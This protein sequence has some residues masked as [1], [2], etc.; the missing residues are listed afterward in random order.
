MGRSSLARGARALALAGFFLFCAGCGGGGRVLAPIPP[1]IAGVPWPPPQTAL[2]Q[3]SDDTVRLDG[4]DYASTGGDSTLAGRVLHL[5]GGA[6]LSWAIYTVGGFGASIHPAQLD[7]DFSIVPHAPGDGTT[8]WI[9]L[10]DYSRGRWEWHAGTPLTFSQV[11]ADQAHYYSGSSGIAALAVVVTGP[12]MASITE[13]RFHRAGATDIPVP[14]NLSAMAELGVVHLDWDDLPV[15]DGF[16]VYR[17][18]DVDFTDPVKVNAELVLESRYDDTTVGSDITY[19]YRVTAM[20]LNESTPSNVVQVHAPKEDLLVPQNLTATADVGLIS[21]E[22]DDVAGVSGYN[23]YRD[24]KPAFD[25]P[26]K[27][28]ASLV[29]TSDYDDDSVSSG[30][31][32]YYCVTSAHIGESAYSN[33]VDVFAPGADLPA[34]LNPHASQIGLDYFRVAWEWPWARPGSFV[35]Y[36]HKIPNFPL[37]DDRE[38]F[39][40]PTG[41]G[42]SLKIT[43][44][45]DS[46]TYYFRVAARSSGGS[47]GRMTDAIAVT[48]KGYWT[49]GPL[50]E[51]GDGSSAPIVAVVQNGDLTVAYMNGSDVNVARRNAGTWTVDTAVLGSGDVSGGFASYLDMAAWQNQYVVASYAVMPGDLWV[52]TGSA[53]GTWT[54]A[55]VDGDGSTGL[56]HT[57]SGAYCKVAA[58]L[59]TFAVAYQ[60]APSTSLVLRTK[61]GSGAWSSTTTLQTSVVEP[62]FHSLLY[63]GSDL[64]VLRLDRTAQQLLLGDADSGWTWTD[65]AG[66]TGETLG[67]Y[68]QLLKVGT[69]FWTPAENETTGDFYALSGDG[70]TFPWSSTAV[71][72]A[73]TLT[74]P[75]GRQRAVRA[76]QQRL[77]CRVLRLQP[78]PVV[79]RRVQRRGLGLPAAQDAGRHAR[80]VHGSRRDERRAVPRLL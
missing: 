52:A 63:D 69:Q 38:T 42:R 80:N 10:G 7:V 44:R 22:W 48:T 1:R 46:T 30:K 36:V 74:R 5:T 3:A 37:D 78:Q 68:N 50:E 8:L 56:G 61:S 53:G 45:T 59:N 66:T 79:L 23:V 6:A 21:L 71:D 73:G 39:S 11:L 47:A 17:A 31:I 20:K 67:A 15:V 14:Q 27:I 58:A 70:A 65:V 49:W 24:I 2:R 9:G 40:Q 54:T 75:R 16:N 19:Y 34:P 72:T 35:V 12:G 76:D 4:A 28:N 60:D 18:L 77:G 57:V 51:I 33:M 43:G 32:Y 41:F 25:A 62:L 64:Y 55:C 13:V 26:A 29:L